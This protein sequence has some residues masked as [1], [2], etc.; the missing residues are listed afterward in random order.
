MFCLI[1]QL[2][3]QADRAFPGTPELESEWE[4]N[5]MTESP[6]CYRNELPARVAI[7]DLDGTIIDAAADIAAQINLLLQARRLQPLT[8][9]EATTLLGDGLRVFASR[10][11]QLRG[12]EIGDDESS[13][14][15]QG[16]LDAPVAQT[17]LYPEVRKVLAELTGEGW[18]LVVCTNK[19]EAAAIHILEELGVLSFF[20]AVCGADTVP[21]CK[22]SPVHLQHA[23]ARAGLLQQRAVMIGDN[24]VDVLAARALGI[25]SVFAGWGYGHRDTGKEATIAAA[26]FGDLPP[27]LALVAG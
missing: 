5:H 22:P 13:S 20:D 25:P 16:Y 10:A 2:A 18:R 24:R 21:C 3:R 23:L 11:F 6:A 27:V 7:F 19:I 14:F 1:V 15:I 4:W 17:R 8:V 26:R 12:A 9:A